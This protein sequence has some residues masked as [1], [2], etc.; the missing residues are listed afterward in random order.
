MLVLDAFQYPYYLINLHALVSIAT[1]IRS[2]KQRLLTDLLHYVPFQDQRVIL[3]YADER[4]LFDV[5]VSTD[6]SKRMK[7]SFSV[8]HVASNRNCWRKLSDLW[9]KSKYNII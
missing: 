3:E 6:W 2:K 7:S 8:T 5:E 9:I 1:N 4:V